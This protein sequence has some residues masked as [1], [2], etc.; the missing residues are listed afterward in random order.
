[1]NISSMSKINIPD[2]VCYVAPDVPVPGPRG[3]SV[4]VLELSKSLMK[5]G[6]RVHVVARRNSQRDSETECVQGITIHRIFR[7][8]AMREKKDGSGGKPTAISRIY[9]LYLR[10]VF[11]MYAAFKIVAIVR[12]YRIG[13][14]LERETA[15]GAGAIASAITRRPL[16]LEIVGPRYSR[17]SVRMSRKILYYTETMLRGWVPVSKCVKVP[18]GVDTESFKPDG[19]YRTEVRD[20]LGIHPEDFVFG[21]IGTFQ[22]WHGLETLL[23]ATKALHESVPRMKV[24]LVGPDYFHY[25]SLSKAMGLSEVCIFPG[26]V[27]HEDVPRY[28]N[29]CDVMVALYDPTKEPL[30]KKY[31]IGFPIKILEYIACGKPVISTRIDLIINL[32][33]GAEGV[34]MTEPGD[35]EQLTSVMKEMLLHKEDRRANVDVALNYSWDELGKTVSECLS[36]RAS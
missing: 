19:I 9:Y 3:S 15:F 18:A 1:M 36:T 16:V 5:I 33:K 8:M 35:I 17:L 31:G 7:R 11:T 20:R 24:L 14:I 21:Y 4:H 23:H 32:A 30:R 28:I 6:Y 34:V 13:S 25:G 29:A 26:P 27:P 2:S 12:H 22:K 10:T